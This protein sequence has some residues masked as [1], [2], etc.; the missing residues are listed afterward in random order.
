MSVKLCC[1]FGSVSPV[2]AEPGPPRLG[3]SP[4]GRVQS[5]FDQSESVTVHGRKRPVGVRPCHQAS[6]TRHK[7][8]MVLRPA[9][10]S[11][12]APEASHA[13]CRSPSIGQWSRRW[14]K[15]RPAIHSEQRHPPTRTACAL[16]SMTRRALLCWS[17]VQC[18]GRYIPQTGCWCQSWKLAQRLLLDSS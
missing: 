8:C 16:H 12:T 11:A 4:L 3:Q 5:T 18:V 7:H 6:T 9:S 2:V 13:R 14:R 15:S 1:W 17:A 10:T